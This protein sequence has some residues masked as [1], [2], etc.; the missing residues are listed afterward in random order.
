MNFIQDFMEKP[1]S[2]KSLKKAISKTMN[3]K[4]LNLINPI[5]RAITEAG[6]SKPPISRIWRYRIFLREKILLAVHRPEPAK[7]QHLQCL[8]YSYLKEKPGT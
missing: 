2:L 4:S 5:I 8:F 1:D 7:R 6:Y 3:F